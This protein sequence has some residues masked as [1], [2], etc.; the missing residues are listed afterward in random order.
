MRKLLGILLLGIMIVGTSSAAFATDITFGSEEFFSEGWG[1]PETKNLKK[2]SS[3]NDKITIAKGDGYE[4]KIVSSN[5]EEWK[6]VATG[7]MPLSGIEFTLYYQYK[8]QG[9]T[10]I[11]KTTV[12]VSGEGDT[13]VPI[14]E[15]VT[16]TGSNSINEVRF[17]YIPE[18]NDNIE[19]TID[20]DDVNTDDGD[21]DDVDTKDVTTDD[22]DDDDIDTKDVTTND[23]DDTD[24]DDVDTKDVTTDD[25]DDDVKN[26]RRNNQY[27]NRRNKFTNINDVDNNDETN[28]DIV[29]PNDKEDDTVS[30]TTDKDIKFSGAEDIETEKTTPKQLE[31]TNSELVDENTNNMIA[32][33]SPKLNTANPESAED[34][35][36][37]VDNGAPTSSPS[38]NDD[39][40]ATAQAINMEETGLPL[41][42]IVALLISL[43]VVVKIKK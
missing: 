36:E 41:G 6:I 39:V 1:S 14:I 10:Q 30:D 15:S 43:L 24:D 13:S 34:I 26:T 5:K 7:V 20:T 42:L 4:V 33:G 23:V 38:D 16:G 2:L 40:V 32:S 21:D 25:V 8:A 18:E 28:N 35:S 9:N 3:N 22:T 12:Y 37:V 19:E 29:V 31:P 17:N 11:F 27:R